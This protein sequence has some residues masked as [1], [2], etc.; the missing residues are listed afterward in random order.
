MFDVILE[1]QKSFLDYEKQ[2][3]KKVEK[4]GFFQRGRSMVLVKNLKILL[5]FIFGKTNQQ[6]VFDV[7]L[8]SQKSFLDY[9]K[10]KSLKSQKIRIF[11]GFGKKF[12]FFFIFLS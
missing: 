5:V 10:T 2:K 1:S 4:S 6:N 12:E 9:K 11:H 3:V 8:E 7:I